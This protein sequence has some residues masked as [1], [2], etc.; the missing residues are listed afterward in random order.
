[1]P[2]KADVPE[3]PRIPTNGQISIWVPVSFA[4]TGFLIG[5]TTGLSSSPVVKAFLPLVFGLVT[6]GAGFYATTRIRLSRM[7]GISLTALALMAVVGIIEGIIIRNDSSWKEFWT[8]RQSGP[9]TI[10]MSSPKNKD[11]LDK[12]AAL[13]ELRSTLGQ[14]AVPVSEQSQILAAASLLQGSEIRQIDVNLKSVDSKGPAPLAL[15]I[16]IPD[17][18]TAERNGVLF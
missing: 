7:I 8:H 5:F 17:E 10:P 11:E 6:G 4:A 1:M 14:I 13:I 2:E 12:Y 18:K 9:A 16:Q 3:H 15:A